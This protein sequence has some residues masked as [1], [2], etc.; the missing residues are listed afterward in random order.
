[1]FTDITQV[2]VTG[3]GW[4]FGVAMLL[5][6]GIFARRNHGFSAMLSNLVITM[7]MVVGSICGNLSD[8]SINAFDHI[9]KYFTIV[10]ALAN[11]NT[12]AR[13]FASLFYLFGG[14]L[15]AIIII[16]NIVFVVQNW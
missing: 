10:E 1:M 12:P 13:F 11:T 4:S 14:G 2:L 15:I 6:F 16:Q 3:M 5:D 8:L 9:S 7:A